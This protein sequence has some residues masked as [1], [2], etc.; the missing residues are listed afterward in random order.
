M[1]EESSRCSRVS[2]QGSVN[3]DY[4]LETAQKIINGDRKDD[5]GGAQDSF[6]RIAKMWSAYTGMSLGP[7]D[8]AMMMTLLKVCRTA[9]CPQKA[10]SYVDIAGYAALAAEIEH[11]REE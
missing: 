2:P 5:Y 3:R 11:A 4:I 1:S 10:D 8:V 7:S 9:T 6:R